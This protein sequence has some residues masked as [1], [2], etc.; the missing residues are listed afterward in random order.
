MG[1]CLMFSMLSGATITASPHA[2]L[3]S[4]LPFGSDR[5]S[6]T[7]S[8]SITSTSAMPVYSAFCA[9][10]LSSARA[11]SRLNL[12]SSASIVVPSW[13]VTPS[14]S[15]NVYVRP[16]SEI[17]QLSARP[18]TIDPSPIKRVKPSNTLEYSTE[19]MA[20]AAAL[21]GS[22]C[23]GSSCMATVMSSLAKADPAISAADATP[24]KSE[25]M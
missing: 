7:V 9:F 22:R 6:L 12:T 14:C 19:S 10:T 24:S 1:V 15:L 17:S 8:G 21:V 18:G 3:N 2:R 13:N 4:R 23:G 20:P 16:S 5:V 11:R 25:R